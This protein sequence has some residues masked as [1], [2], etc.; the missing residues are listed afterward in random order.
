MGDAVPCGVT[1]ADIYTSAAMSD[2]YPLYRRVRE[3][4]PVCWDDQLGSRGAWMVTGFD[5]AHAILRDARFSA[6]RRSRSVPGDPAPLR[7][8][9]SGMLG[10]D[11]PAHTR[12]RR[13]FSR[14]YT[15]QAVAGLRSHIEA[16]AHRLLDHVLCQGQGEMDAMAAYGYA[17]PALVNADVFG[18]RDDWSDYFG[19]MLS[20][21]LLVDDGPIATK[22]HGH[23]LRDI[24]QYGDY[25]RALLV[26]P[27]RTAPDGLLSHMRATASEDGFSSENELIGNLILVLT[28]GQMTTAHEI[29]NTL[30]HV[31]TS[32]ALYERLRAD[33]SLM[34][35]S[36]PE[37]LRY[38]GSVQLTK[39]VVSV[40][41]EVEG[42]ELKVGDE[43]FIWLGAANRDPT[44]FPDPD[45]LDLDRGVPQHLSFSHGLHYCLGAQLGQ[46]TAEIGVRAFIERVP[47]PRVHA[48]RIQRATTATFH[49]PHELPVSFG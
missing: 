11:P 39:R 46:L 7:L 5:A 15:P 25:F 47:S 27:D 29:G 14:T 35:A 44:R 9:Y 6:S 37:F 30:I 49:G 17:L 45:R 19:W 31:L 43:V 10:L 4:H 12:V 40:S 48:D 24:S 32:R 3:V 13:Q 34:T 1:M 16:T 38:D 36:M 2:P 23:L 8:M 42:Q 21:G 28:A 33:P 41:A 22:H 18:I 20:W 26:E